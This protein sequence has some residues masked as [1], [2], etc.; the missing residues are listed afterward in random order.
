MTTAACER[1]PITLR[2]R[3]SYAAYLVGADPKYRFKRE[4][5]DRQK[6]WKGK[7]GW[8]AVLTQPGWVEVKTQ[9]YGGSWER[10]YYA[11]D[12]AKLAPIPEDLA[13]YL[14]VAVAG[15]LPGSRGAFFGTVCECGSEAEGFT[16]EGFPRCDKCVEVTL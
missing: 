12:G 4:W 16:A 10:T 13:E 14:P 9:A 3:G 5:A 11:F 15:P 2:G 6:S 7:R 8:F 1:F